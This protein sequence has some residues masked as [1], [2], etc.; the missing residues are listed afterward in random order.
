MIKSKLQKL[1]NYYQEVEKPSDIIKQNIVYG[2]IDTSMI[3]KIIS[4]LVDE[5]D[6][7]QKE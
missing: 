5:L 3:I 4:E 7:L 2:K 6:G 1:L